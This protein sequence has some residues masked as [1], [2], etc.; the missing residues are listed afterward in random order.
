MRLFTNCFIENL[1]KYQDSEIIL[2]EKGKSITAGYLLESSRSLARGLSDY[3]VK[4]GDRVVLAVKPGVEFL[5]VMYANMMLGTVL[6]IIDPEMGRENYL[7][8]LKQ[9]SPHHAFA[10][11]RLILLNEHPILKFI[12]Q[13]YIKSLPSF[14]RIKNCTLFATGPRL[15]LF[16]DHRHVAP[17]ISRTAPPSDFEPV[18]EKEDFLVTYTSGTLNEPKGVVHTYA[19]LAN[20]IKYLSDV[21]KNGG[22]KSIATHLPHFA[23]IGMSARMEVHVWDYS[24]HP[25][26]KIRFIRQHNITTL[27]GPPSDFVPIINYINENGESLPD[28]LG[29]IFLGSAPIYKSFLSRL[30]PLSA[31]MKVS[32]LYG[33][34]ENLMVT[35]Q[36]GREKLS[37]NEEGD[38]VGKPFP[39]VEVSIADDSEVCLRSDQMFS[40]Y[41][42]N[43]RTD[44]AHCTGDLG[45]IDSMGRLVL[46]GRKKDM[47]IRGNFNIYP[48]LYEPTISRIKDV[49]EAVMIG[50]YDKQ[51]ADEQV[52]LV[53]DATNGLTEAG[54]MKHLKSG[55]Y[56]I[57]S[58]ALPDRILFRKIP[59]SGRQNKVDR[60]ALTMMLSAG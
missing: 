49:S 47:I 56:S 51:K 9:F 7:A 24:M 40:H 54:L 25:A 8:K 44:T 58:Q 41:W 12:A 21:L 2:Y 37:D 50:V 22:D 52:V 43:D 4:R 16:Q 5:Q 17:L 13:R 57:D 15:P 6:S 29:H 59:H 3:G 33:M 14:P 39:G 1:T 26:E 55:E 35:I 18:N 32:C 36:D 34:T 20:S 27:F 45:R 11:S 10:D 46:I 31:T 38:L 19:S 60:K 42:N 28:C 48:G 53:V 30:V 23:L